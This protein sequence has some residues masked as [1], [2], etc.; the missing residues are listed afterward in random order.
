MLR[1]FLVDDE[2][3]ALKRLTRMLSA[4]ERVEI[5]GSTTD[6]VDAEA[7]LTLQPCDLLF[8]DIEMPVLNGFDLLARLDP[9][10]LVIFTTAYSQY[11]LQAFETNSIDYLLKPIEPA[12]LDRA[13]NKIERIRGGGEHAPD[14][15]A[16]ITQLRSAIEPRDVKYPDRVSSRTGERIEFVELNRITHFYA[17]DKLTFAATSAKSHAIDLTIAELE[18]K[19]D[20]RKFVRIHRGTLVNVDYVHELHS[21]FGGKMLL[22]LKD[23]KK[24]ELAVSRDRAKEI[25]ERLGL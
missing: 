6:P 19:L 11:A 8:L 4:T 17:S 25:K 21:W 5:V 18:Q 14:L 20:P 16:L 22:R 2:L 12:Q 7:F 13:L 15:Q 10:P 3:L 23:E 24:T 9:Q 1:A